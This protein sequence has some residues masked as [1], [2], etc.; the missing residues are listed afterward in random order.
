MILYNI[1]IPV[2]FYSAYSDRCL[3][4]VCWITHRLFILFSSSFFY[5]FL[6]NFH[7][8]ESPYVVY[9]VLVFLRLPS[10]SQ[11]KQPKYEEKK[12]MH[13]HTL[14]DR[15]T[16]HYLSDTRSTAIFEQ[17][18]KNRVYRI[19]REEKV[20]EWFSFLSFSMCVCVFFF[21]SFKSK[22]HL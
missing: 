18:K 21:V 11:M 9:Y 14:L 12:S 5:M 1:F 10:A 3:Y 22:T 19:F 17:Q 6:H 13:T 15:P 7:R 2:A 16:V 8:R 4:A 20:F